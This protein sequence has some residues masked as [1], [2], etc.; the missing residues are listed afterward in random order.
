MDLQYISLDDYVKCISLP[1]D[2]M[3][4]KVRDYNVINHINLLYHKIKEYCIL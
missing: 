1:L 4:S 2:N 3:D